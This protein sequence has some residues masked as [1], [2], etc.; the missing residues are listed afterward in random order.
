MNLEK[1]LTALTEKERRTMYRLLSA[2]FESDAAKDIPMFDRDE[3]IT[4]SMWLKKIPKGKI[5]IE[6]NATLKRLPKDTLI[7]DVDQ[8]CR[9]FGP[10]RFAELIKLRGY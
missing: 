9:G 1:F 5:S 6:L 4:V 3:N 10:I 2:E 7:A 8:G